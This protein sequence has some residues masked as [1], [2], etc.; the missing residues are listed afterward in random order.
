M[1]PQ[2]H[3]HHAQATA[4][5]LLTVAL[6]RFTRPWWQLRGVALP[7]AAKGVAEGM[8]PNGA[9][10]DRV[11]DRRN[12]RA[13]HAQRVPCG[14]H[15]IHSAIRQRFAVARGAGRA[16]RFAGCATQALPFAAARVRGR[17]LCRL[18][19]LLVRAILPLACL[20]RRGSAV[21]GIIGNGVAQVLQ[22]H[23]YL[24]RAARQ[25]AALHQAAAP[26]SR[27]VQPPELGA[28]GFACRSPLACGLRGALTLALSH[29]KCVVG[30]GVPAQR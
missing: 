22:V 4:T 9:Q 20:G 24:M 1:R 10:V 11:S 2:E 13:M 26:I 7:V 18:R 3:V 17:H 12:G 14:V 8:Q 21:L 30:L 19:A 5:Y 16:C 23:P 29:A 25:R 28:R 15:F 27:Q 6:K